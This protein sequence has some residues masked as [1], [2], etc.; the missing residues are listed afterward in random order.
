MK[1]VLLLILTILALT[2]CG[3]KKG[4]GAKIKLI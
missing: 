1:K 2:A 3:G 4:S